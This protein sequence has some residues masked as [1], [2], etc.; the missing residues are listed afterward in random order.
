MPGLRL[1]VGEEVSVGGRPAEL[2]QVLDLDRYMVRFASRELRSVGRAEIDDPHSAETPKRAFE[3]YTPEEKAEAFR[4][5]NA[6]KPLLHGEVRRGERTIAADRAAQLLGCSRATVYR[7]VDQWDGED[8]MTLLPQGGQGQ[9]TGSRLE[10]P[11]EALMQQVIRSHYLHRSQPSPTTVW[12]DKLLPAFARANLPQPGRAT[13]YRRI[14]ELDPLEVIEARQGKRAARE[15][16]KRMMGSYPFAGA[17]LSSVQIDY[18]LYDLEVVD[19]TTRNPIGR[20]CL[21]ML[22]DT[23]SFMPTG[24]YLSLDPPG[25]ANAGMAIFHSITRKEKWLAGLGVEMEWPVWGFM[26]MIH[27]DNAKEFRGTMMQRFVTFGNTKLVNRKVHTP[28]YGPHIERYFGKLAQSVKH[29]P[30]ATGSNIRERAKK[31]DPRKTASL[32]LADLELYLLSVIKEHINTP[33]A[34][35]G[36]SPLEKWRSYFF[37]P[38][39]GRQV[40]KLPPE[41]GYLDRLRKELLPLQKRTLQHYGIQWDLFHYDSD[42]LVVLRQRHAKTPDKE[43]I[44]RRDPHCLSEVYVWDDEAKMYL[45]VPLR[46]PRGVPMNIWEYRAAK[47]EVQARTGKRATEN[48]IFD[49]HRERTERLERVLAAQKETL[50]VRRAAQQ[51]KHHAETRKRQNDVIGQPPSAPPKQPPGRLGNPVALAMQADD[52]DDVFKDLDS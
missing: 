10:E 17:Q 42:A 22:I 45:T 26:K 38:E 7:R 2:V 35:L 33:R 4:W 25:A 32:T 19:E 40:Q 20:P 6:V 39:T 18:W 48:D 3:D 44:V 12:N 24:Y 30:G 13:F 9:G 46:N 31:R 14:E 52:F 51:K 43:F 11:R 37:D 8:P 41:V 15:A 1:E 5:F 23:F 28:R 36:M 47:K 16:K 29:L 49:V 21:T 34:E 27:A 50:R